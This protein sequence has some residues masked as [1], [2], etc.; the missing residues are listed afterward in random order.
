MRNEGVNDNGSAAV[1]AEY[2]KNKPFAAVSDF[3]RPAS[4][5]DQGSLP[6]TEEINVSQRMMTTEKKG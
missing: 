1:A 3:N 5:I 4:K 6:D 2:E